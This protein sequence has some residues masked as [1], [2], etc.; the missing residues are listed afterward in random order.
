MYK[1]FYNK[2]A[3]NFLEYALLIS[4]VSAAIIAMSLYIRRS[5]NARLIETQKELDESRR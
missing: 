2:K 3:Q 1:I 4:V 5:I